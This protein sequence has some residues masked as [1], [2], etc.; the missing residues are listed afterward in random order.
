MEQNMTNLKSIS[1]YPIKGFNGEDLTSA[2]LSVGSGIINDR[3]FAITIAPEVDGSEW[4][5]CLSF[6]NNSNHDGL[7]KFKLS[8]NENNWELITPNGNPLRFDPNEQASIDAF[9]TK[10]PKALEGVIGDQLTPRLIERVQKN[11][12]QAPKQGMWDYPDGLLTILNQESVTAF[13]KDIEFNLGTK[14][15]R[16]NLVIENLPAWSEFSMSGKRFALGDAEIEISRPIDRCPATTV[17]SNTGERD[18]KTPALLARHFGHAFF[19]MFA[20][21]VKSGKIK[22]TDELREIGPAS[23]THLDW[24]PASAP[25][26][27]I[28]PKYAI[29]SNLVSSDNRVHLTL[30]SASPWPLLNT[31]QSNGKRMR[32]H[33][34]NNNIINASIEKIDDDAITI[35][36][37]SNLN[38]TNGQ[39]ILVSGPHGKIT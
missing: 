3:R 9:N 39:Q 32:L 29:I 17:N 33:L 22:P 18:V 28:W 20:G 7:Q 26:H 15:F 5:K 6:V 24:Q 13:S 31:E 36:L 2:Y 1:R 38:L 21:V 4:T 23:S 19:G 11:K 12:P 37:P 8:S 25:P 14:R 34:G 10:L 27:Q 30:A 35:S 16:P